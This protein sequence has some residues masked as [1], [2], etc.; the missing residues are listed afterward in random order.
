ML[1]NRYGCLY[2]LHTTPANFFLYDVCAFISFAFCIV[3]VKTNKYSVNC[4]DLREKTVE[5]QS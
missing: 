1:V 2:E 5:Y 3:R 4:A